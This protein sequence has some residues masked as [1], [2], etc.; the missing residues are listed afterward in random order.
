MLINKTKMRQTA[1][2]IANEMSP[3]SLPNTY[4]DNNGKEWDYRRVNKLP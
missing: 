2:I 3:E 4:V 1:L